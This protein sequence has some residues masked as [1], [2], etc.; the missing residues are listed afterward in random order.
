MSLPPASRGASRSA[1]W[2]PSDDVP[3]VLAAQA[4]DVAAFDSLY[5]RHA[6]VVHGVLLGRVSREVVDDLV[7]EVFIA[8]W[9]QLGALRDPAAFAGWVMTIARHQRVDQA[10]RL[11]RAPRTDESLDR[12][13]PTAAHRTDDSETAAIARLEAARALA[14][15]RQL[16]EAYRESLV[17]RLV[18]GLTGP[19]IAARTGLTPD[20][21]RVNLCRGM[22]L[23][24]QA[25]EPA[26]AGRPL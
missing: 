20:S 10:R 3:L 11:A 1:A 25:L 2:T 19:E 22:K 21:V 26:P 23:L 13:P 17:L 5:R 7:Q 18:E 15:I 6:R 16:P 12:E 14:A 4:G 9:R 8:A 24:R